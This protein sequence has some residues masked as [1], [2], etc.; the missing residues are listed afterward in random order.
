[1]RNPLIMWKYLLHLIFYFIPFPFTEW[2]VELKQVAM[3][4]SLG[5]SK[6]IFQAAQD[7]LTAFCRQITYLAQVGIPNQLPGTKLGFENAAFCRAENTPELEPVMLQ[8][9]N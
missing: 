9:Y 1:M 4:A 2:A 6:S 7:L 8:K 5:S 3:K